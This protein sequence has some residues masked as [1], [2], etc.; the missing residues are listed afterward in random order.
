MTNS[1]SPSGT[2]LDDGRHAA[3][4]DCR[5]RAEYHHPVIGKVELAGKVGAACFDAVEIAH[6]R[7]MPALRCFRS[8]RLQ[9]PV[10]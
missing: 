2:L 4:E 1:R 3:G 5:Q 6:Q 10:R 8:Q 7:F 9:A